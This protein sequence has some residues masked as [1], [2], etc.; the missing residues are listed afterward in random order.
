MSKVLNPEHIL[1]L[2]TA[3]KIGL[4]YKAHGKLAEEEAMFQRLLTGY[5]KAL[6]SEHE[7]TLRITKN[8]RKTRCR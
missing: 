1:L 6:G 2:H 8:L 7:S 3:T 4:L 5:E